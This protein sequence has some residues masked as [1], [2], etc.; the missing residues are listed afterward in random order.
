MKFFFK[1]SAAS[2]VF[3]Y[4]EFGKNTQI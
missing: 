4:A 2:Y 3:L 1:V